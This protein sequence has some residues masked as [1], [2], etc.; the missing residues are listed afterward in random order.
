MTLAQFIT[1]KVTGISYKYIDSLVQNTSEA[2]R[3]TELFA[4]FVDERVSETDYSQIEAGLVTAWN[5][6]LNGTVVQSVDI[7]RQE[8]VITASG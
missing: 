6:V 3:Y 7:L 4:L 1:L 5:N 8:E 2:C